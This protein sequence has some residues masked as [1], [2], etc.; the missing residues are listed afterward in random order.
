MFWELYYKNCE[1]NCRGAYW[2]EYVS[3]PYAVRIRSRR[4]ALS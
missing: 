2:E 4:N 3:L 1:Q